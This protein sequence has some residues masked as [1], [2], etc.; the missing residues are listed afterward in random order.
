MRMLGNLGA[1]PARKVEPVMFR[2]AIDGEHRV[3][4]AWGYAPTKTLCRRLTTD[5][6]LHDEDWERGSQRHSC[7]TCVDLMA[8]NHAL[9]RRKLN[10]ARKGS[11]DE[12]LPSSPVKALRLRGG[13]RPFAAGSNVE[14]PCGG[15]GCL[16]NLAL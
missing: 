12:P 6:V 7:A 4:A 11:P 8:L 13:S 2:K 1:S 9:A 14:E 15:V 16:F 3:H 5:L 10:E